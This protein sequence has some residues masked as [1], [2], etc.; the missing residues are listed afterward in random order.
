MNV[1]K[2]ALLYS[3]IFTFFTLLSLFLA[4]K[5]EAAYLK[6]DKSA[7]VTQTNVPFNLDV[8]VD[9]GTDQITSTDIWILYDPTA[10]EAQTVTNGTFFD[11]VTNNI[12]SGKVSVTALIVNPGTYKTG[13]GTI[14]TITFKALKDGTSNLTFDCRTDVSNSSKV[15]KNDVNATNIIVC[16]QNINTAVTA[17]AGGAVNPT[18][19]PYTPPVNPTT[20]PSLPNSGIVENIARYATPGILLLM[21]GLMLRLVL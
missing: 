7:V 6:F 8:I 13:S 12:T 15:I 9:A 19:A 1:M 20:P 5:T 17:G 14:A 3:V 10:L 16:T 2:K 21:A 18:S 4:G 11:A